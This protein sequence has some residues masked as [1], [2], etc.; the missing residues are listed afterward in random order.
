MNA[1]GYDVR[2]AKVLTDINGTVISEIENG[3]YL[4]T[5]IVMEING[6]GILID[7]SYSRKDN[8]LKGF[9][10]KHRKVELMNYFK[11]LEIYLHERRGSMERLKAQAFLEYQVL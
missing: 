10:I 7:N 9:N 11:S 5:C 3:K 1:L 8:P 4:H 2:E 6:K